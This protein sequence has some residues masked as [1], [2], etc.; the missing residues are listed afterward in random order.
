LCERHIL[1][2]KLVNCE[3]LNMCLWLFQ[4]YHLCEPFLD[5]SLLIKIEVWQNTLLHKY[6]VFYRPMFY[7]I[8]FV[9][10]LGKSEMR[11]GSILQL[12]S[13]FE[14]LLLVGLDHPKE[15][16]WD[17]IGLKFFTA[18]KQIKIAS[19]NS[20]KA[21]TQTR[22]KSPSELHPFLIHH[23]RRDAPTRYLSGANTLI[24]Y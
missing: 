23:G 3:Y 18:N 5:V 20:V 9:L 4:P 6:L 19:A 15:T 7:W 13:A 22:K 11:Y 21:L 10:L 1:W 16:L 8:V 14:S 17:N 2:S 12:L 24:R